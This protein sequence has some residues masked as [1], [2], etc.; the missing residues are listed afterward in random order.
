MDTRLQVSLLRDHSEQ[1]R[2]LATALSVDL[3]KLRLA[4]SEQRESSDTEE[5]SLLVELA[6]LH[7]NLFRATDTFSHR[8][9]T[10][11]GKGKSGN[12]LTA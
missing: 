3:S 2:K 9:H 7:Q 12:G 11:L 10:L 4:L 8:L 5:L 1:L 6:E